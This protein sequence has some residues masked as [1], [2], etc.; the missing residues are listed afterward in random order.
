VGVYHWDATGDFLWRMGAMKAILCGWKKL[1][2]TPIRVENIKSGRLLGGYD[3]IMKTSWSQN[4][5]YSS[6]P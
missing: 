1:K 3:K 6:S 5:N 4:R 2:S